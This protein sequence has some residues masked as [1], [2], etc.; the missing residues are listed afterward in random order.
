MFPTS[1]ARA[2]RVFLWIAVAVI[3][4]AALAYATAAWR[5]HLDSRRIVDLAGLD[6]SVFDAVTGIRAEIGTVGVALLSEAEPS[7][8]VAGALATVAGKTRHVLVLL[9]DSALADRDAL[10]AALDTAVRRLEAS[11]TAVR[12]ESR[13]PPGAR[14]VVRIEPWRQAIYGAADALSAVGRAVGTRLCAV[15]SALADLVAVREL[16]YA[17]RD[18]YSRQCSGFR[19][20]VQNDLPLTTAER[21]TWHED[22]GAYRE[23]WN[24]LDRIAAH[25]PETSALRR[26]VEAGRRRTAATQAVM[27]RVLDG[28]SGSGAPAYD[29][30]GWSQNCMSAYDSILAIGF[31]ALDEAVERAE[32]RRAGA[33]V[34]GAGATAVLALALLFGV[35]A[36]RFVRLRLSRPL[37]SLRAAVAR[38]GQGDHET[39]VAASPWHDEP[40][41]IAD[42]LETLRRRALESVRLRKRIDEMRDELVEHAGRAS[43]AKSEFLATM[44][45]EL[46]TPLN[47][48]LGTVQL[49]ESSPVTE[50]QQ[51]WLKALEQSGRLLR[52]IVDDILDYT[53]IE[54][55]RAPVER[56]AFS[57]ADRIAIV[58]ATIAPSVAAKGL[59]FRRTIDAA[60]PDRLVGDP[61]KLG[62]ILLNLLGNAVKFTRTGRVTLSVRGDPRP[63]GGAG[64]WVRFVVADTG[65]GIAESARGDLFRPFTQADG[66]IARRF[67]GSGLGLAICKGLVDL[68]GGEIALECPAEGGTVFTVRLPFTTGDGRSAAL[69]DE[70]AAPTLPPLAVLV[71]EDNPVNAMV[72]RTLLERA[73]HR[74]DVAGDGRVAVER[75]CAADFDVV[76]MDLSMP[77]VDGVEATRR[78]RACGH[79]TRAMVPI[80]A[81]TANL[82]SARHLPGGD[83]GFDGVVGKP[84]RRSDLERALAAAIGLAPPSAPVPRRLAVLS[85][86]A[87][88]LSV[89][90]ARKLVAL[91]L[92]ETP[93][94][95]QAL[96]RALEAADRAEAVA[97][98]HRMK[99][100]ARHVG[101]E[102]I[103]AVAADIER[104]AATADRAVLH[105]L[106]RDLEPAVDRELDALFERA[107]REFAALEAAAL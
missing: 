101:A 41:A 94:M 63:A 106:A 18:R 72:A 22:I 87:R 7:A 93:G 86:Q 32:E 50:E 27:D 103:A 12:A 48:I 5:S 70:A 68:L 23:L 11:E 9:R 54:S 74:V 78:I 13:R 65:I 47:G 75:A 73:G 6:R 57:L 30:A 100:G 25:L 39:P 28:L 31:R 91:Y 89:D 49:L 15:D 53:R 55:G 43:R 56:V 88:D 2:V 19:R 26:L 20:Q 34:A 79:E 52:E 107:E 71:A 33:L 36:V 97:L 69:D 8:T 42:A 58:E 17:I 45:H 61:G 98:A 51:R 59:E 64:A 77:G 96:R 40:G 35:V 44:S 84:Y 60:L 29:A 76:L 62:Q 10:A 80:V 90:G 104:E 21:R 24:Q 38:I 99:G 14:D 83:P 67:G 66:S 85:E 92:S 1:V 4:A 95:A 102:A 37:D 16:S 3:V 82:A 81:L 46:R 105:A